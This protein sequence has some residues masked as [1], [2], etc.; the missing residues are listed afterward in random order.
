MY[1]LQLQRSVT[2][3]V[4]YLGQLYVVIGTFG[5]VESSWQIMNKNRFAPQGRPS[6]TYRS[7]LKRLTQF[8]S[9]C[10]KRKKQETSPPIPLTP[11]EES[12]E[13]S[14]HFLD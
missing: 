5:I 11:E 3:Q 2:I 4:D 9:R 14:P 8:S 12:L 7:Q 1:I 10:F 13:P 6:I